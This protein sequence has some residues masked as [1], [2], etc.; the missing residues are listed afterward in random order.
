MVGISP[1]ATITLEK[2]YDIMKAIHRET[3]DAEWIN[4]LC[5]RRITR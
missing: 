4:M 3:P 5:L 1:V 2:A